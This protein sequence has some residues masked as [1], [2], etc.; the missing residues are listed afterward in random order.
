[1]LDGVLIPWPREVG[2]FVGQDLIRQWAFPGRDCPRRF[3]RVAKGVV[4]CGH[5]GEFHSESG[6]LPVSHYASV[7]LEEEQLE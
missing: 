7:V 1:M 5:R 2:S 6:Y 4:V 3:S